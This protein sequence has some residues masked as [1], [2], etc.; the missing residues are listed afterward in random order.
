MKAWLR[1][2]MHQNL[3]IIFPDFHYTRCNGTS[4][5]QRAYK[6]QSLLIRKMSYFPMNIRIICNRIFINLIRNTIHKQRHSFRSHVS[7]ICTAHDGISR[8]TSNLYK[9]THTT[10]LRHEQNTAFFHFP[11]AFWKTGKYSQNI[12][13]KCKLCNIL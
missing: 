10:R 8:I 1:R 6:S 9:C 2:N 12:E 11:I 3:I 7:P 5:V 4:C 13:F